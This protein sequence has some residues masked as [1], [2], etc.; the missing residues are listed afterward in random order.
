MT[1][2]NAA[3]LTVVIVTVKR[4]KRKDGA[5]EGR[6]RRRMFAGERSA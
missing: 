2:V 1:T 3:L 6:A 5:H 4:F